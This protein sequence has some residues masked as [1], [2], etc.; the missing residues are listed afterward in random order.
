[1]ETGGR[2]EIKEK[3][4]RREKERRRVGGDYPMSSPSQIQGQFL[5][6][7][8][9]KCTSH[10]CHLKINKVQSPLPS[11]TMLPIKQKTKT[12]FAKNDPSQDLSKSKYVLVKTNDYMIFLR[13]KCCTL[14]NGVFFVFFNILFRF[15]FRDCEGNTLQLYCVPNSEKLHSYMSIKR[16]LRG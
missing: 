6:F 5:S 2:Q 12:S 14:L 9:H 7:W 10:P 8:N 15:Q 11:F 1:M 4:G 3:R 13:I 16:I